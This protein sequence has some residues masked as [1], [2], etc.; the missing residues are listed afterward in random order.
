MAFNEKT[1]KPILTI[2]CKATADI[3]AYRFVNFDCALPSTDSKALG[4][5]DCIVKSGSFSGI[6]TMGIMVVECSTSFTKGDPVT[7]DAEGKAKSTSVSSKINGRALE[8]V[9]SGSLVK[10]LLVP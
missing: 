10:I 5:T 3:P 1:N 4:V 8:T 6:T 2:T 9:T 7:T